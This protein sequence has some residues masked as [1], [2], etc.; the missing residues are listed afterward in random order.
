MFFIMIRATM[1][2]DVPAQEYITHLSM[3]A[4]KKIN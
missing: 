3:R 1:P 4:I 2:L